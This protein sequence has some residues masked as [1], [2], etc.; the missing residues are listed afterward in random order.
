[1]MTSVTHKK[2][3]HRAHYWS[4]R[5]GVLPGVRAI[6]LS[7]SLARGD[8][9]DDSDIDFFVVARA[10]QIWTARFFVFVV[11]RFCN[12][13]AKPHHHAG[14]ICP[15]H[16]ITDDSLLIA[17]QD[18]YGARLFTANKPLYDPEHFFLAFALVNE[19]WVKKFGFSFN[20]KNSEANDTNVIQSQPVS[21]IS[22]KKINFL[23]Q[24]FES[25]IR[26]IQTK[27]IRSNTE[28]SLAGAKIVLTDTELRFH[29]R[30]K[31]IVF[32]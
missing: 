9:N 14:Q 19:A 1:M 5:L 20:L 3:L 25:F 17:E 4:S 27:K 31:N 11:L 32:N 12:R 23:A 10:G 6:F 18:E 26:N 28:I 16:F 2:Y 24:Y 30:P 8:G 21:I 29:P 15:N 13:L 22:P 7:G